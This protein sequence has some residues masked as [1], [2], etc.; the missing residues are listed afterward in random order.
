M[1]LDFT[2]IFIVSRIHS[3]RFDFY[4]RSHDARIVYGDEGDE[5]MIFSILPPSSHSD[6]ITRPSELKHLVQYFLP[7]YLI[8]WGTHGDYKVFPSLSV[9]RFS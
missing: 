3:D 6:L 7:F 8:H 2:R 9:F 5:H 4:M 1:F